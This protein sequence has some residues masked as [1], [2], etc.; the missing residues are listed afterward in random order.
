MSYRLELF[1]RYMIDNCMDE[2]V[3]T[4]HHIMPHMII[5]F[6]PENN[7]TSIVE[8]NPALCNSRMSDVPTNVLDHLFLVVDGILRSD[9]KSFRIPVEKKIN[10]FH[11][12]KSI[13]KF[14]L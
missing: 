5:I 2:V 3:H 8:D 1:I 4:H 9:V 11:I 10:Q 12:L 6:V 13:L 7:L 14:F